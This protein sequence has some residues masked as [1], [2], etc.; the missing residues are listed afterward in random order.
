MISA[1]KSVSSFSSD[2]SEDRITVGS[3]S[4]TLTM[5]ED[6]ICARLD[7]VN[8]WR[9]DRQCAAM[10]S[11]ASLRK[12]NSSISSSNNRAAGGAGGGMLELSD[13]LHQA[14]K[15]Q[16]QRLSNQDYTPRKQQWPPSPAKDE[17]TLAPAPQTREAF[18]AGI[19]R[20]LVHLRS[21]HQESCDEDVHPRDRMR[22]FVF[23]SIDMLHR[24]SSPSIKSAQLSPGPEARHE[25]KN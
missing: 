15:M 6:D 22:R 13:I 21:E 12:A 23:A 16:A 24:Q 5:P 3:T 20:N 10:P 17:E 18:L 25:L 7:R 11:M 8:G 1:I 2:L 19:A 4:N 14:S 9:L